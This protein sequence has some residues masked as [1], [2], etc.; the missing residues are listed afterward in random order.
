[1]TTCTVDKVDSNITGLALAEE[2]CLKQLPTVA[3]DGFAP[4]WQAASET[5]TP[6]ARTRPG[7]SWRSSADLRRNL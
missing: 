1:M 2:I 7:R 5:N 6:S 3:S 4:E